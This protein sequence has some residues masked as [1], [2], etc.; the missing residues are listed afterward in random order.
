MGQIA[1]LTLA[2]LGK[3]FVPLDL[4]RDVLRH[5]ASPLGVLQDSA[6][7]LMSLGDPTCR[8]AGSALPAVD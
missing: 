5:L 6:Y 7:Q 3:I 2:L 1:P 4:E 8:Q